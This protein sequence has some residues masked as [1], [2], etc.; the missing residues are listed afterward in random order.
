[1]FSYLAFLVGEVDAANEE[2]LAR[3]SL[4]E[5][6]QS[7]LPMSNPVVSRPDAREHLRD[8]IREKIFALFRKDGTDE[9]T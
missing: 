1:M 9:S 4:E 7:R 3:S 6:W 5:M 2:I 8:H